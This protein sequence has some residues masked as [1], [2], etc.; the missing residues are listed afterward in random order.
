MAG[1]LNI[2]QAN[3]GRMRAPLDDPLMEG[4]TSRLQTVNAMADRSPGFIWRLQTEEGDATAIKA[5]DDPAILFNMSVWESIESL[6]NY[7]YRSEHVNLVR[8]RKKWFHAMQEPILV[9]W[10]VPNGHIPT[11]EEAKN[12]LHLLQREGPSHE[13]F[14]FSKPFPP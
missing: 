10:W 5:F 7:V 3:I 11:I 9:L 2:A 1:N 6:K 4:F 14:T 8:D 13:A 12:K